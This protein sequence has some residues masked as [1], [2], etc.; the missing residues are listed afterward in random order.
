MTRQ[1]S[2][3]GVNVPPRAAH[4]VPASDVQTGT[5]LLALRAQLARAEKAARRAQ[6]A[7]P[8]G[9]PRRPP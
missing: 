4:S 3:P 6:A 8:P 1:S 7:P 2:K 9:P 5:D